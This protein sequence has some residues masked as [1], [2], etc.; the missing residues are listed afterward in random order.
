[1]KIWKLQ[2]LKKVFGGALSDNGATEDKAIFMK[3]KVMYLANNGKFGNRPRTS[4]TRNQP[5]HNTNSLSRFGQPSRYRISQSIFH[6]AKDCSDKSDFSQINR[7]HTKRRECAISKYHIINPKWDSRAIWSC[8]TWYSLHQTVCGTSWQQNIVKNDGKVLLTQKSHSPFKLGHGSVVCSDKAITI[9][10]KIRKA[11][12]KIN[13]EVVPIELQLLLSKESL[14]RWRRIWYTK[15][16]SSFVW[17]KTKTWIHFIWS[18]FSQY[19]RTSKP[20]WN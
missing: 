18:L 2:S 11:N 14:K 12:C 9:A 3:Q 13:V 1:M 20:R 10:A 4:Q 16:W 17:W 15:W 6:Y 5:N 7:G 19:K 8:D